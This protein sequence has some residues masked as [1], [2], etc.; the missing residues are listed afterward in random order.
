MAG[1]SIFLKGYAL[2]AVIPLALALGFF[3]ARLYRRETEGLLGAGARLRLLRAIAVMLMALLLAQ[4][5]V[6]SVSTQREKPVVIV[7]RDLSTS[8]T[9][10]DTHEPIERRV[11][12]AVAL[13]LFD[14]KLRDTNAETAAKAFGLAQNAADSAGAGVRQAAQSLQESASNAA[15]AHERVGRACDAL[16]TVQKEL[17][18]GA[19]SLK[20]LN[21]VPP[22]P[23][24]RISRFRP[25]RRRAN[26]SSP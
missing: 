8:M 2:W 25:Q 15:G 5:V 9:V 23:P 3:I 19:K 24:R 17:E 22:W 20:A 13:G 10:K 18:R 21:P 16:S 14:G 7:L 4:P 1:I 6:H 26:N 11:R 12:T